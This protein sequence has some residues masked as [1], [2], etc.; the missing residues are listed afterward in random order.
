MGSVSCLFSTHEEQRTSSTNP[1]N[2]K[3]CTRKDIRSEEQVEKIHVIG[4]R[5]RL[6]VC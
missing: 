5:I 4:E 3:R 2:L 6:T 1:G